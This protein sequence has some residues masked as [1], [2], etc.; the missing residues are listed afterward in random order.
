[1]IFVHCTKST[2]AIGQNQSR[3]FLLSGNNESFECSIDNNARKT[4]IIHQKMA[5]NF[6][7]TNEMKPNLTRLNTK[8]FLNV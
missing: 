1:M 2:H 6:A 3:A 4:C 5:A 8:Q 7:K